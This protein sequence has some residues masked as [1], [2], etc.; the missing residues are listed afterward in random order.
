MQ[1]SSLYQILY[2]NVYNVAIFEYEWQFQAI[3]SE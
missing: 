1:K 2:T 3:Q